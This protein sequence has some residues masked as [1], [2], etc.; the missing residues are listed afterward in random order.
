[1]IKEI[2]KETKIMDGQMEKRVI[3]QIF[4]DLKKSKQ[5]EKN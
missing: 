1:M 2:Q 4:S 3:D 5:E